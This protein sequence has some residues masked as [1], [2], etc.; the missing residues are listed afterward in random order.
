VAR[1][2]SSAFWYWDTRGLL[3]EA[4]QWIAQALLRDAAL[5]YPWRARVRVYASYLAYRHGRPAEAT[6]LAAM[7]IGDEQATAEDRGLALRLN[8]LSALQADDTASARWHFEQAL[9]FAQDHG[10]RAAVAAAQYNLG[11]LYL[12]EGELAQAE[13]LLWAS[14]EPWEQQQHPRYIGIALVTLGYIAALRGESQQACTLLRDG[15]QQLK[16]A[17]EMP[18]LLYGLL[19]CAC[20]A[21]IQQ[22]PLCAAVLFGAG[23]HHAAN[24]RLIFIRGV[25][26]RA[27]EHIE[28]ARAQSTPAAFNQ[29]MRRGQSLALDEAV[30]LAQSMFDEV[31]GH[32]ERV[33]ENR[34]AMGR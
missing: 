30:T 22:R 9:A 32:P 7:V 12:F 25:L 3:E 26:A 18:Y 8:G 29:A 23:A 16:L 21:S 1:L 5:P 33:L 20:F 10:L 24:A 13:S 31:D 4:Q 2:V 15:L 34:W 17:Q 27:Q 19:A 11:L 28:H 6:G 14:Y